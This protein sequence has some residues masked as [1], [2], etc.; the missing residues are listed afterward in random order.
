MRLIAADRVDSQAA[1]DFP[2]ARRSADRDAQPFFRVPHLV[3]HEVRDVYAD[4]AHLLP[5]VP[6]AARC[7]FAS[8]PSDRVIEVPCLASRFLEQLTGVPAA[9]E[10]SVLGRAFATS[11]GL[12]NRLSDGYAR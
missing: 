9:H 6:T 11:Y 12:T 2:E 5:Q 10:T 7:R 4:L 3:R 1:Y 8:A